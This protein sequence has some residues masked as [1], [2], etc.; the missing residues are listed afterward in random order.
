MENLENHEIYNMT[1]DDF[2]ENNKARNTLN[3]WS[4]SHYFENNF[5]ILG[6]RKENIKI[7]LGKAMESHGI[8]YNQ[9]SALIK[10]SWLHS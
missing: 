2:L 4:F 3:K 6:H 7:V 8:L 1:K 5:S 10:L 9:S